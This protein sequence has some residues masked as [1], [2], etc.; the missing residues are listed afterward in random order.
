MSG[1]FYY[2]YTGLLTFFGPVLP[3]L[4]L[5][6][7]PRDIQLRNFVILLPAVL[8]GFV[9]YPLWHKSRYGP[10][11][12]PLGIAR[13]WAHVFAIWDGAW[14]RTMGWQPTRTPGSALWRF[15]AWVTGWSGGAAV[16]WAGL[17]IW[18]TVVASSPQF[19]VLLVFALVNLTAV[20]RVV[21]PGKKAA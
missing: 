21:F 9:L 11:V 19:T 1:F 13:G 18:R 8:T 5:I 12:W 15:R 20:G 6:L 7:F 16:I 14:G 2:A 3:I 4:L 10:A 17:A